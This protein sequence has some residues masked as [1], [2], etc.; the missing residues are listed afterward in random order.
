MCT[1]WCWDNNGGSELLSNS[2]AVVTIMKIHFVL[3]SVHY[4]QGA[5]RG[6]SNQ[7]HTLLTNKPG[8]ISSARR[9]RALFIS[10]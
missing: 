8:L 3:V 9:L 5:R 7:L 6:V 1:Q 10:G 4:I 2:V